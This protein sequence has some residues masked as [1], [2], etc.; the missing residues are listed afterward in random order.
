M[1]KVKIES[2]LMNFNAD[3]TEVEKDKAFD[4]PIQK[5]T[6]RRG[7]AVQVS[8]NDNGDCNMY[9]GGRNINDLVNIRQMCLGC[10]HNKAR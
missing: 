10:A 1:A 5:Y 9:I 2:L 3:C 4:C 8:F 7:K 6:V